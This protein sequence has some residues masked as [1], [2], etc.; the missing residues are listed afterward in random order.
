[1]EK[2]SEISVIDAVNAVYCAESYVDAACSVLLEAREYFDV[3]DNRKFLSHNAEHI[4][5]LL[6]T[7]DMLLLYA[8][9]EHKPIHDAYETYERSR[10]DQA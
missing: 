2:C 10:R 1:M 7:V 9:Q 5:N 6:F 4:G 8:R 3:I